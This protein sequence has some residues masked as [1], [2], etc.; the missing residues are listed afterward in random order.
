M[1]EMH[2]NN[3]KINVEWRCQDGDIDIIRIDEAGKLMWYENLTRC[4]EERTATEV[5]VVSCGPYTWID[6]I[7]YEESTRVVHRIPQASACDSVVILNLEVLDT[8]QTEVIQFEE[9]ST[10]LIAKLRTADAYQWLRCE[11]G[12]YESLDGERERVFEPTASGFYAVAITNE[13]CVDTSS[14]ISVTTVSSE[15]VRWNQEVVVYPNP[16]GQSLFI[17]AKEGISFQSARLLSVAG[18][19]AQQWDVINGNQLQIPS[20]IPSGLYF[21]ELRDA[22]DRRVVKKLYVK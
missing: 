15:Q 9:S 16:V 5:E 6:G 2:E 8:F 12:T 22:K 17:S 21:L 19:I 13:G 11:N 7:T 20:S 10:F 4:P 14:C 18:H 1:A 3:F